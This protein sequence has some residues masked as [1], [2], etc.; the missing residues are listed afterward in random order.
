MPAVTALDVA[1]RT[2]L[3]LGLVLR[4]VDPVPVE[5]VTPVPPLA[6][7][8]VPARVIAP[9]VADEGVRPVVPPLKVVT[10]DPHVGVAPAPAEVR[11]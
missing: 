7:A 8:S 9:D 2:P 1:I 5:V 11:T 4:T 10:A 3:R 6:T